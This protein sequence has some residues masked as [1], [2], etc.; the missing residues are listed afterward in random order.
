RGETVVTPRRTPRLRA[1]GRCESRP[2]L[3]A[4]RTSS[5]RRG[6]RA[7]SSRRATPRAPLVRSDGRRTSRHHN[8]AM[9]WETIESITD[10]IVATLTRE[11][12]VDAVALTFLLRRYRATGRRDVCEALEPALARALEY[13]S[14]DDTASNRAAWLAAFS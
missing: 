14:L 2:W 10:N 5:A 7:R 13:H 4:R 3:P 1:R 11:D 6:T 8:C 9:D 12:V